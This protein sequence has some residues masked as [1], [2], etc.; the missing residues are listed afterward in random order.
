ML[1]LLRKSVE[2]RDWLNTIEPRTVRAVMKRVIEDIT[3]IGKL[4]NL[5]YPAAE[6]Q[7]LKEI[8][9]HLFTC[10][11]SLSAAYTKSLWNQEMGASL[12]VTKKCPAAFAGSGCLLPQNGQSKRMS[13]IRSSIFPLRH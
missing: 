13:Y 4:T 2:T 7:Q 1:Q 9:C 3:A 6:S 12:A 11:R 5:R 8:F 10:A